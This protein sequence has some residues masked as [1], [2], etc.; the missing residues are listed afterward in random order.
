MG[1]N[2]APLSD[3]ENDLMGLFQR[4]NDIISANLNDMV[5]RFEDPEKML[6]QAVREME[7]AIIEARRETARAMASEKLAGKELAESERQ[8]HDWVKRAEQA[9]RAGD[10]AMARKALGR[11]QEHDKVSAALRDQ[12]A[13][14]TEASQSLRRQLE[15]MQSKLAEATRRLGTLVAR[16]KAA[17][18]RA[19]IQAGVGE[20]EM[21]SDA[22]DKFERLRKKVD[23]V[24]AETEALRELETGES[25][26]RNDE[27]ASAG[28]AGV[29]AELAELKKKLG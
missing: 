7:T 21:N 27:I 4:F 24:E 18:V 10:D 29:E 15:A 6:K 8:S 12:A 14:T 19:K 20:V 22:F 23:R 17:A 11:K 16:Q 28:D 5:D 26:S 9:V 13:A 2:Q 1:K 25:A 3:E